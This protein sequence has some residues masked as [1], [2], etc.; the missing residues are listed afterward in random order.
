MVEEYKK[1]KKTTHKVTTER[2]RLQSQTDNEPHTRPDRDK[3][4]T[5]YSLH[6]KQTILSDRA[7]LCK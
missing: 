6:A 7:Y 2:H 5:K 3:S 4:L 1:G